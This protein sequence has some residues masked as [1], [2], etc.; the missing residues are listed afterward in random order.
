MSCGVGRRHGLDLMWLWLWL[1]PAATA[2]I[3]PPAWE[4][5]YAKIKSIFEI[6]YFEF[7]FFFLLKTLLLSHLNSILTWILIIFLFDLWYFITLQNFLRRLS[8]VGL[9]K[10]AYELV[11]NWGPIVRIQIANSSSLNTYK[12]GA[13]GR[14][15]AVLDFPPKGDA[16]T[17]TTQGAQGACVF[18]P[19]YRSVQFK[20][21]L[22]PCGA[23]IGS[24]LS[25]SSCS[26]GWMLS[27]TCLRV[28][29]DIPSGCSSNE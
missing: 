18:T 20:E 15:G 25:N 27:G 16:Q 19:E 26:L 14:R 8:L 10:T 29:N 3:R 24:G 12:Y 13:R 4:L 1:W 2:P 28:S 7:N 22:V 21:W 5:P 6:K 17:E 9:F 23:S 11:V